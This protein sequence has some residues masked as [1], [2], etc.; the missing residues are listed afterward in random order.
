MDAG[1]KAEKTPDGFEVI[2]LIEDVSKGQRGYKR[3]IDR[4]TKK[5][6][7][8]FKKE[9]GGLAKQSLER[10]EVMIKLEKRDREAKGNLLANMIAG[11][12]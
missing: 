9:H 7:E 2:E 5:Y 4:L 11:G 10:A 3:N 8:T 6:T 1:G 12:F